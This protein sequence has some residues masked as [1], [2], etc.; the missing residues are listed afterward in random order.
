[1]GPDSINFL[2]RKGAQP[3]SNSDINSDSEKNPNNIPL[4]TEIGIVGL[5]ANQKLQNAVLVDLF[6]ANV[7]EILT[8]FP[9]DRVPVPNRYVPLTDLMPYNK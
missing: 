9:E 6:L 7:Q 5:C 8:A 4:G 3:L 1:M 2:A